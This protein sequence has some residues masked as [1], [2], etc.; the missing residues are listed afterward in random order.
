[1][2]IGAMSIMDGKMSIGDL[3]VFQTLSSYFTQPIQSLV[4]LQ[5]TFQE[6]QIAIKRLDELMSLEGEDAMDERVTNISLEGDIVFENVTFAYGSRP[7]VLKE[8][9]L[10]I[11]SGMRV[12]FVGESGAGK[13]TIARLLM[14]FVQPVEG[15]ITIADFDIADMDYKFLRT[16]TAYISQNVEL[17][18]GTIANNLKV[19]NPDATYEE[20]V[21]ACKKSGAHE[22]IERLPNRYNAFIEEAG[23]NLS[24]GEKQRIAIARSLLANP[25]IY[26]FDEATSNLDSFHELRIQNLIFNASRD[27]KIIIIAH[28]LSTI[29]NCDLICFIQDGKIIEHGTHEELLALNGKYAEMSRL[30]SGALKHVTLDQVD[31]EI[32]YV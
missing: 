24:G 16:N 14:K 15:K 2:G 31:D 11:K 17:F 29:V 19:G 4:S 1:M 27:K 13:S 18:T 7:P 20:M 12:A 30:Q 8:F 26:I 23:A 3:L 28:R 32:E 9:S 6:A 5:L 25:S 22:F 21:L 10:K